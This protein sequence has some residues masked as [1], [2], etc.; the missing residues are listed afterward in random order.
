MLL[1]KEVLNEFKKKAKIFSKQRYKMKWFYFFKKQSLLFKIIYTGSFKKIKNIIR[2]YLR[3]VE[4]ILHEQYPVVPFLF[5]W[6][7]SVTEQ[8][9]LNPPHAL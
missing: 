4:I 8:S 3:R 2:N 6:I 7:L 5:P 1:F 9:C